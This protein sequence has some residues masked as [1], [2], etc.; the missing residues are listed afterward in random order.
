MLES[1]VIVVVLVVGVI[2]LIAT[3]IHYFGRDERKNVEKFEKCGDDLKVIKAGDYLQ[4]D[5]RSSRTLPQNKYFVR[6][7]NMNIQLGVNIDLIMSELNELDCD[8]IILQQVAVNVSQ[9]NYIDT[10]KEIAKSLNLN[11]IFVCE[12]VNKNPNTIKTKSMIGNAILTKF[13]IKDVDL[14]LL[15]CKQKNSVYGVHIDHKECNKIHASPAVT[16]SHKD[17]KLIQCFCLNLDKHYTG[18]DGRKDTVQEVID[19]ANTSKKDG[20]YQMIVGNL[21][22]ICTG[23]KKFEIPKVSPD[24]K[25]TFGNFMKTEAEF[26][27]KTINKAGFFDPFGKKSFTNWIPFKWFM[28]D[29]R[30]KCNK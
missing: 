22:T 12:E 20:V 21:N 24:L 14:I 23:V 9:S 11:Y 28:S 7:A 2:L 6:V 5:F 10:G 18:V 19:Y 27:D 25:S 30:R 3:N 15:Q 8:L 16:L 13:D 17:D 4:E 26:L 29:C 1:F